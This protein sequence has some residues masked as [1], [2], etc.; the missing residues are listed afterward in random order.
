MI[1]ILE[2]KVHDWHCP[3]CGATDQTRELRPH[4]RMHPCPAV[5]GM[6]IP[7][8]PVGMKAKVTAH[9]REDYVGRELVQFD[10]SGRP[11]MSITTERNDG[12]QDVRVF[13]PTA[14]GVHST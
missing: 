13:A 5:R 6:S 4:S 11:I 12:A 1:P 7:Y 2:P 9:D 10:P 8:L 3:A 14:R